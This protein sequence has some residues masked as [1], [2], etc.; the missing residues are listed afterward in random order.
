MITIQS[1]LIPVVSENTN[2]KMYSICQKYSLLCLHTEL[3]RDPILGVKHDVHVL[4]CKV[5]PQDYVF[6]L[7]VHEEK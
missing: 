7:I 3:E 4:F 6:I 5:F 2:M 1:E